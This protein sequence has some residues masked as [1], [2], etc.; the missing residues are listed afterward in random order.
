MGR[1]RNHIIDQTR[2]K[3]RRRKANFE[4]YRTPASKYQANSQP[5]ILVDNVLAAQMQ[6]N[7]P[8][9]CNE[10]SFTKQLEKHTNKYKQLIN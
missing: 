1:G 7:E 9:R 2:T 6:K 4:V 3:H 10:S 5:I 8:T